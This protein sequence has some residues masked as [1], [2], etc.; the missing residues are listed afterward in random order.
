ML[1][2]ALLVVPRAK[3]VLPSLGRVVVRAEEVVE[4]GAGFPGRDGGVWV[5]EGGDPSVRVDGGEGG[6]FDAIGGVAEV[7]EFDGVGEGEELEGDGDFVGVGACGVGVE[8]EWL[9]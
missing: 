4:A 9:E 2:P 3:D 6:A 7:P 1:H 8:D 5:L